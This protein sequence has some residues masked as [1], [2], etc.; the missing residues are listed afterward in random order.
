MSTISIPP[1]EVTV[2]HVRDCPSVG[3]LLD[4]LVVAAGLAGITITTTLRVV[5]S[6]AEA[7]AIAFAGSPTLLI[8]GRDPFESEG[9]TS[10]GCRFY[11]SG[12]RLDGAP[13]MS[14]LTAALLVAST[15]RDRVP[16]H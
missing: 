5:E 1:A 8:D 3:P 9:V 10:F 7:R 12:G 15:G 6:E 13:S 2:L 14:Q 4:R 11:E 16:R